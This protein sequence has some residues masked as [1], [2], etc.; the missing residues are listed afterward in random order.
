M[1]IWNLC[2]ITAHW[3]PNYQ[4][5]PPPPVGWHSL[6]LVNK[7]PG[8]C[9]CWPSLTLWTTMSSTD[10]NWCWVSKHVFSWSCNNTISSKSTTL[11]SCVLRMFARTQCCGSLSQSR[12]NA[13]IN[14]LPQSTS[15]CTLKYFASY[16]LR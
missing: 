8:L 9:G 5:S 2:Y 13:H 10:R 12:W 16:C 14:Q 3:S 4:S 11:N 7:M 6:M 15:I 1:G